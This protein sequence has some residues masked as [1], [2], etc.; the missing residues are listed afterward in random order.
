MQDSSARPSLD[1][2]GGQNILDTMM[3]CIVVEMFNEATRK[4]RFELD[5]LR[6]QPMAFLAQA[7]DIP[8]PFRACYADMLSRIDSMLE[9][10]EPNRKHPPDYFAAIPDEPSVLAW[11]ED[12]LRE[13]ANEIGEVVGRINA[14]ADKLRLTLDQIRERLCSLPPSMIA[15]DN[16][17]EVRVWVEFKPFDGRPSYAGIDGGETGSEVDAIEARVSPPFTMYFIPE[18]G[19]ERGYNWNVHRHDRD[20]P[21]AGLFYDDL[22][23][24]VTG[25]TPLPEVLL[26][27]IKDL[28]FEVYIRGDGF[29][30]TDPN[31]EGTP[32]KLPFASSPTHKEAL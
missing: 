27:W 22:A 1:D 3:L 26:P 24:A 16:M 5:F 8:A 14:A 15:W 29:M 19:D 31:D 20:H 13:R 4:A 9:A 12:C 6:G 10:I 17:V 21:L 11:H 25:N 7:Q 2:A 23:H 18:K 32:C 28:W 30:S